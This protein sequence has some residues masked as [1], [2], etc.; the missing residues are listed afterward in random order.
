MRLHGIGSTLVAVGAA[1]PILTAPAAAADPVCASVPACVP[2]LTIDAHQ[3][4]ACAPKG[5]PQ[6][7]VLGVDGT[8]ARTFICLKDGRTGAQTWSAAPPLYGV[9]RAGEPC[10]SGWSAQNVDGRPMLCGDNSR[11]LIYTSDVA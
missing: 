10:V 6:H 11:W 5:G 2:N 7:Y 1:L 8:P 3:G 4:M 9:M